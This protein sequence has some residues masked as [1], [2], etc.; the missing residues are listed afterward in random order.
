MGFRLGI[1]IGGTF[2]DAVLVDAEGGVQ[3]AKVPSTPDN[4]V[5][6]VI[7][8]IAEL[9]VNAADLE[10]F[11]HGTTVATN[12]ILQR[13]GASVGLLTTKG[14]KDIL[15]IRRADR[16]KM[17]DYFWQPPPPLA[18]RT[19]RLEVNERVDYLGNV[20]EP[21]DEEGVRN[22]LALLRERDVSAVAVCLINSFVNPIHE[23]RIK[24]IISAEWPEVFVSI[25]SDVL[26]EILE[27]ERTATTVANA[28]VGP[29]MNRYLVALGDDLAAAGYDHEVLVMASSGGV[30]SAATARELPAA[31][32]LSGLAAGVI[33]GRAIAEQ[34]GSP[35]LITLDIGGTSSDIAVIYDGQARITTSWSIEFG[36]PIHLPAVDVHTIGAGGGSI[37]WIDAGGSLRVGP[38]SAGADPGP[39]CY[40]RGGSEPTTTDAMLLLGYIDQDVWSAQYGWDLDD[41]AAATAIGLLGNQLG[42]EAIET[43]SAIREVT[44]A[45]LVQAMRLASIER[46]YDPRDFQLTAYGGA[47]PLFAVDI[48][49]ELRIPSVVVP[50]A[51][52]VTSALGL[53]QADLQLNYLRSVLQTTDRVDLP[54]LNALYDEMAETGRQHL[55]RDGLRDDQI[56]VRRQADVHYFGQSKYLTVAVPDGPLDQSALSQ[57]I[58]EFNTAHEREYGYVMPPTAALT[59]IANARVVVEGKIDQARV[60]PPALDATSEPQLVK[61]AAVHFSGFGMTPTPFYQRRDLA[62]GLCLAGPAV[63]LQPDATVLVPPDSALRVDP[64]GNLVIAL[65][66]K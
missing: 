39:V 53:L 24:E 25:S 13:K 32:A 62:P 11:S 38:Q 3:V 22:A 17:Y 64:F 6:G 45:N 37:A 59:E 12:A 61:H 26:P 47:G 15:E 48:A 36:L 21:L 33:A 40:G 63:V 34:T 19:N 42:L 44:V 7:N 49:R 4:Y 57:V 20:V 43:A 41:R 60:R 66:T 35:H 9:D 65:E 14:F 8:A 28:Y 52:G 55:R 5:R 31:T 29:L 16:G 50:L 10:L 51:P 58:A 23:R 18:H 1:D 56:E 54:A 30:L 2:T 27:F 46:G